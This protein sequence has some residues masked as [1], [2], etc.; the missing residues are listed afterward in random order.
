MADAPALIPFCES[1]WVSVHSYDIEQTQQDNDAKFLHASM[2]QLGSM[3]LKERVDNNDTNRTFYYYQFSEAPHFGVKYTYVNTA[4]PTCSGQLIYI[5]NDG[6]YTVIRNMGALPRG[7]QSAGIMR[8]TTNAH[9]YS[10]YSPAQLAAT[11]VKISESIGVQTFID[12]LTGEEHKGIHYMGSIFGGTGQ[13]TFYI[14]DDKTDT[15]QEANVFPIGGT[16]Y[17]ERDVVVA[18]PAVFITKKTYAAL[19]AKD[20]FYFI[21]S[22][23]TQVFQIRQSSVTI[24]GR[25]F[26]A[27]DN[28]LYMRA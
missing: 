2:G 23:S 1:K 21:Y 15:Y 27:I 8:H 22:G 11:E 10:M 4:S 20:T 7:N 26:A 6:I 12:C 5:S 24:D 25:K 16:S 28:Q 14:H 19:H 17:P 3:M 18:T 9:G 13:S